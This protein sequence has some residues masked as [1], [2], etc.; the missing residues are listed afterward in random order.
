MKRVLIAALAAVLTVSAFTGAAVLTGRFKNSVVPVA[1]A[2]PMSA[3][4]SLP[5][6][7]AKLESAQGPALTSGAALCA[8]VTPATPDAVEAAQGRRGAGQG[9]GRSQGQS[10]GS[11]QGQGRPADGAE[12]L[13]QDAGQRRHQRCGCAAAQ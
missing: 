9:G 3:T 10:R 7:S 11:R 2:I 1:H 12:N 5:S 13:R 6:A 8:A 4:I